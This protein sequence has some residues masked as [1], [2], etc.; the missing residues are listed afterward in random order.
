MTKIK[1]IVEFEVAL[2]ISRVWIPLYQK[3]IKTLN[4]LL[5]FYVKKTKYACLH[6]IGI[7][8]KGVPNN[9]YNFPI[10]QNQ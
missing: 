5:Q 9:R 2:Y 1:T 8:T 4:E 3:N 7:V 10:F 6:K